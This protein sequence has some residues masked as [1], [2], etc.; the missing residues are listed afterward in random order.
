V[1]ER[2]T[3]DNQ[4]VAYVSPLLRGAGVPHAFST[5]VG[6]ISRGPFDSLNLGNPAGCEQQDAP[7]NI[8]ANYA[9]LHAAVGC[10]GRRRV[11]THQVHGACVVDADS[12]TRTD[13]IYDGDEIGQADA[14]TS[15]DPTLLLSVRTADCVPV[16]LAGGGRVAAVHAG[17]RG[18]VAGVVTAA[19]RGFDRPADV[20]AAIGP[21]IG[22]D[23]FEVGPDV[24][25][26]FRRVFG[27][28]APVRPA[29]GDKALVDLKGAIELQL[30]AAGVTR[31]DTTDCCTVTDEATFFSHRRER[32]ITGRMAA[33]IG[34]AS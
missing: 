27:R 23:A 32:G 30:R 6:G 10:A 4:V 8:S 12:A 31:L 19:L 3:F 14:I 18:V 16:L 20:I 1:L 21:S 34:A 28:L 5:R 11:F 15:G 24:A 29:A 17:W 13:V 9:R 7:D 2:V 25:A 26:E 33:V 22:P